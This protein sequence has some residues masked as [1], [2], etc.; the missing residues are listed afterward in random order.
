MME[1]KEP[2]FQQPQNLLNNGPEKEAISEHFADETLRLVKQHGD[3][4][5]PLTPEAA[6][7]LKRKIQL[8]LLFMLSFINLMLF[9]SAVLI[10]DQHRESGSC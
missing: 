5:G 3:Q 4:V 7:K 2:Y 8:W 10:G 6:K 9:V 1:S